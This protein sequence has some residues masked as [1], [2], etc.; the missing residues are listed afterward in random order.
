MTAVETKTTRAWSARRVRARCPF[1]DRAHAGRELAERLLGF[2]KREDCVV[3][4]LPRGGVPVAYQIARELDLPMDVL[5]AG[6]L[7]VPGQ[8]EQSFGAIAADQGAFLDYQLIGAVQ[9][10]Q[11]QVSTALELTRSDLKVRAKIY[12][13]AREPLDVR[14]KTVLL[15]DDGSATGACLFAG[16]HALRRMR[17]ALCVVALP[18]CSAAACA[19]LERQVDLLLALKR[20]TGFYGLRDTYL[21][22][23]GVSDEEIARLLE[24]SE[25]GRAVAAAK[26]GRSRNR[27]TEG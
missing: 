20:P 27:S 25:R 9:L 23:P 26:R 8:P 16:V 24:A 19:L 1:R 6:L 7:R 15:V 10:L 22:F 14:G 2:A 17:P 3:L 13:G 18:V 4:A 12:R 11:E 5:V 21:D